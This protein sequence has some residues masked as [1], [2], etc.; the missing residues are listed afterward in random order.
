MVAKHTYYDKYVPHE[1][2]MFLYNV[3][4]YHLKCVWL[5][6]LR[7]IYIKATTVLLRFRKPKYFYIVIKV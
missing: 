7:Q 5:S 3:S 6:N 4:A 1:L 2:E